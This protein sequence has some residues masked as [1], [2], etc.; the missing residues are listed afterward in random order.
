MV[1]SWN[2]P[3]DSWR[4][5]IFYLY[6]SGEKIFSV[7]D[8]L[9]LETIFSFYSKAPIEG[10]CVND[11]QLN[12]ADIYKS[13]SEYFWGDG[14]EVVKGLF[15]LTATAMSDNGCFLYF[16]KTSI[17]DRL[18]WSVDGGMCQR[19]VSGDGCC[20]E[21]DQEA[22]LLLFISCRKKKRGRQHKG[23]RFEWHLLKR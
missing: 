19:G 1:D 9:E 20:I 23:D 18:V 6:V 21:C 13:A 2:S 17:G 16:I 3:G 4:N 8:V 14:V 22:S 11:V 7:V 10:L 12:S 5:G 15:D